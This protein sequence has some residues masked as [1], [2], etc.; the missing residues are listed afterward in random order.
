[1]DRDTA[2]HFYRW[3]EKYVADCEQHTVEQQIHALLADYPELVTT[4]GWSEMRSLAER[5]YPNA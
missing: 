4:H 2:E 1:M 5:N 3:L